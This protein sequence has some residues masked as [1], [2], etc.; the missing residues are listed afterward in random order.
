MKKS[1]ILKGTV[2]ILGILAIS[3]ISAA[4]EISFEVNSPGVRISVG[5]AYP[6]VL[7]ERHVIYYEPL[8]EG[9][10]YYDR[11]N[12]AFY[13]MEGNVY[14]YPSNVQYQKDNGKHKGWNKKGNKHVKKDKGYRYNDN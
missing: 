12:D 6:N 3:R 5:D 10:Y 14:Y 4:Q 2:L 13:T 11:D 8:P 7:E 9:K 1:L